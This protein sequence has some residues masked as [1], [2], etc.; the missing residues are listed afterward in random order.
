MAIAARGKGPGE[1]LILLTGIYTLA[2]LAVLSII[3][4]KTPWNLVQFYI[5]LLVMAAY[6]A[7][8]IFKIRLKNRFKIPILSL[9]VAAGIYWLFS[10][11]SL[12]Y[13]DHTDPGNPYVYAHTS[14]D[15]VEL[16]RVIERAGQ[17]HPDG[18]SL[19]L[20]I[21]VPGHEY[22]P[23]PWYLRRFTRTSW[24][25]HIPGETG[26]APLIISTASLEED[27]LRRLYE[28]PPPGE[29]YLYVQVSG[30]YMELRHG[31]EI[32][33]YMRSDLWDLL[34]RATDQVN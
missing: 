29:R 33:V 6:A 20:D 10:S 27:L 34:E 9:M 24:R 22:W 23:M 26:P 15:V 25:D 2:L 1:R 21:I 17:V 31:Q 11:F 16:C 14:M 13:R 32:R 28:L 30:D 7:V 3:P 4:Y 19:P 18:Y 12:N 8:R 5:G